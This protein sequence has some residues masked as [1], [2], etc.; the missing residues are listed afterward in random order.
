MEA[1]RGLLAEKATLLP[2]SWLLRC[3]QIG[4]VVVSSVLGTGAAVVVISGPG[5]VIHSALVATQTVII[6]GTATLTLLVE[7]TLREMR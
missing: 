7:Q 1:V 5:A 2:G 6:S 4:G 3:G